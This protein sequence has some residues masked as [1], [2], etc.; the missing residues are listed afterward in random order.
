VDLEGVDV[1]DGL[2]HVGEHGSEIVDQLSD[3]GR[4]V[5]HYKTH[6]LILVENRKS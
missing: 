1:D 3:R 2:G 5:V 6:S 4:T